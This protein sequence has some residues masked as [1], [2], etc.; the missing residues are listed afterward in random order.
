MR[1]ETD[2]LGSVAIPNDVLYGIHAFRASGNFANKTQF[3]EEW[4][5]AVGLVK[6]AFYETYGNFRSRSIEK[7]AEKV[8]IEFFDESIINA[9]KQAATEVSEGRWFEHFL[10]PAVQGGAGTSINMNINEIIANRALQLLGHK[11]GDYHIVHPVEHANIFQSTNDVIPSALRLATLKKLGTLEDEINRLRLLME[12]TERRFRNIPRMAYTQMQQA[13][14]SSYGKLFSTYSDALSRDWWRV[15]K[16][17]ERIKVVNLGGSAV[18]TSITVPRYMVMEVTRVLQK[19]TGLPVTRGE[20]LV[21]AT[22]NNDDLVEVH[23][24]LKAHAVNL[25]KIASD[26][27][28]LSSDISCE[29]LQISQQQVGSSIMP[30]KINPVIP[31]FII[32]VAH[33]VYANDMLISSLCAQACLELNA[34]IPQIG[35]ALLS[36]LNLLIAADISFR[37]NLLAGLE[38]NEQS[39]TNTYL[40]S[41]ALCTALLPYIGY[42]K[43]S[44]LAKYMQQQSCSIY[45]AN[46]ELHFLSEARLAEALHPDKLLKQGFSLNDIV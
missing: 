29:S 22:A 44:E 23:A 45:E 41:P 35:D 24:I 36:S 7:Y 28:L 40:S 5:N 33:Q 8:P 20:N 16:C 19:N 37:N 25:E 2:F 32:S 10:V 12:E 42:D 3:H 13:V 27:R 4:Y 14:P 6:Y 39:S 17:F 21:D 31:E 15:S 18:G 9:L 34:Y 1:T 43:A 46:R 38:V 30:G 26:L 11:P